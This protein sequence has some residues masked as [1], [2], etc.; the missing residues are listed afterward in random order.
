MGYPSAPAEPL[1][2]PVEQLPP[3]RKQVPERYAMHSDFE[4]APEGESDDFSDRFNATRKRP[5][6]IDA[7]AFRSAEDADEEHEDAEPLS[8]QKKEEADEMKQIVLVTDGKLRNLR[9]SAEGM[10]V[11]IVK[12]ALQEAASGGKEI[13]LQLGTMVIKISAD[14][15]RE[16]LTSPYVLPIVLAGWYGHGS[17]P[18]AE[19][20]TGFFLGKLATMGRS[21]LGMQQPEI[22]TWMKIMAQMNDLKWAAQQGVKLHAGMTLAKKIAKEVGVLAQIKN[23]VKKADVADL[24]GAQMEAIK[25]L[26]SA[27]QTQSVIAAKRHVGKLP[28]ALQDQMS[29]DSEAASYGPVRKTKAIKDKRRSSLAIRD[30]DAMEEFNSVP[31]EER[32][33]PTVHDI[34]RQPRMR[35]R[36]KGKGEPTNAAA[37]AKESDTLGGIADFSKLAPAQRATKRKPQLIV[38]RGGSMAPILEFN[39]MADDPYVVRPT[40]Q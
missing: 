12:P 18:M 3:P 9:E 27:L 5:G 31:V 20:A 11:N 7:D 30:R 25:A 23:E 16:L 38:A 19:P 1:V 10:I 32:D 36:R 14:A 33:N 29:S 6:F 4:S 22:S 8:E 21:L 13:A 28:K 34:P 35:L 40:V 26:T 24:V 15:A 39:E 2:S 37:A 17:I